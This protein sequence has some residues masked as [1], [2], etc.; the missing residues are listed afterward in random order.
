MEDQQIRDLIAI[1]KD[2]M[3]LNERG[4]EIANE[5]SRYNE[6]APDREGTAAIFQAHINKLAFAVGN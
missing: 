6:L 4:I 1:L 3:D 5:P 2:R